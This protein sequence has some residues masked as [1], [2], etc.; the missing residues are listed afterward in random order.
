[1]E[2]KGCGRSESAS[3][4]LERRT[5]ERGGLSRRTDQSDEV[6]NGTEPQPALQDGPCQPADDPPAECP[7]PAG[8]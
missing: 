7:P 4:S 1:M 3:R 6:A 2:A 8:P 5:Y